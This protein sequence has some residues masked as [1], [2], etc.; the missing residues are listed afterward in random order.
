MAP[1]FLSTAIDSYCQAF[2]R[3]LSAWE[4]PVLVVVA[5]AYVTNYV[6][7]VAKRPIVVCNP[8]NPLSDILLNKTPALQDKYWPT[9]W[10]YQ[11]HFTTIFRSLFKGRKFRREDGDDH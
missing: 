3:H 11:A 8:K 1:S 6:C 2:W 5:V 4:I 9:F 10:C 7:R